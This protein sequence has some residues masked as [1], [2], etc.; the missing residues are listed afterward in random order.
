MYYT[1]LHAHFT[2][3]VL[4][5]ARSLCRSRSACLSALA[6][7]CARTLFPFLLSLSP[8]LPLFK[9]REDAKPHL[10]SY[11]YRKLVHQFAIKDKDMKQQP[12]TAQ[13][14]GNDGHCITQWTLDDQ[15]QQ[16]F[17]PIL[18][19]EQIL[20]S[21]HIVGNT[22]PMGWKCLRMEKPINDRT[23]Y[24]DNIHPL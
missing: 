8:S 6:R 21:E 14:D 4:K 15:V 2:V 22:I 7:A 12:Y 11:K 17:T 16:Q 13:W 9:A 10:L 24:G 3:H 20:L 18:V 1:V 19:R 23:M 5:Q